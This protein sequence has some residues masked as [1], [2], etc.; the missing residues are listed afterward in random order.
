VGE[1]AEWHRI[2]RLSSFDLVS[3]AATTETLFEAE[4]D[5]SVEELTC[6]GLR[7]QRPDLVEDLR[8]DLQA[9]VEELREKVTQYEAETAARERRERVDEVLRE[10]A[11]QGLDGPLRD[12]AL[13]QAWVDSLYES[14][15]FTEQVAER[16]SMFSR[17]QD[18]VQE[19][20]K[21]TDRET[22][23]TRRRAVP[24]GNKIKV[25]VV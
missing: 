10:S 17:L 8:K 20:V 2:K 5:M 18:V 15:D 9:E 7:E 23:D 13:D 21:K 1:Y 14:E 11:L 3:K 16:E 22:L 6:E 12:V 4:E 19:S 25:K 24:D